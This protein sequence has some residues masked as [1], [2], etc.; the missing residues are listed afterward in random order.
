MRASL[1]ANGMWAN[2]YLIQAELCGVQFPPR[3]PREELISALTNIYR[4]LDDRWFMLAAI[5]ERQWPAL[6]KSNRDAGA[7]FR[8][9]LY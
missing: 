4:T 8:S 5:N 6:G 2:A 7:G 1:M 9:S 3:P